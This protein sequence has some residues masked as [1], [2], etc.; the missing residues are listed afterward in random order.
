MS[1]HELSQNEELEIIR[2][3]TE[4][5]L[6]QKNIARITHHGD[7]KIREILKKYGVH[8]TLQETNI[9]KFS[10]NQD[11]FDVN[12]QSYDAAYVMGLIAADGMISK[13]DN[14]VAIELQREDRELLE[15]VNFVLKNG[16]EVKDYTTGRGYE[17]SKIYFY[18]RKMKDD[19]AKFHLIPNKTYDKNYQHPDLLEEKYELAFIRGMFDGDGCITMVN[20]SKVPKWQID[21]SSLDV[22]N[23]VIKVFEKNNINLCYNYN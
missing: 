14:Q 7:E 6:S 10:I 12:N 9:S 22:I 18:N 2:L 11:F 4:E 3:Y 15:K 21:S 20:Q 8:K 23:W 19:L 16:R 1:K 5:K 13:V 17:N